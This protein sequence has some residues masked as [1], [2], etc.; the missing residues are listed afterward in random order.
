MFVMSTLLVKAQPEKYASNLEMKNLLREIRES[1]FN[2]SIHV[3]ELVENALATAQGN[4][5]KL[6]EVLV[7]LYHGNFY[8]QN[9]KFDRSAIKYAKAFQLSKE[10]KDTRIINL[11][12]IR[13]VFSKAEKD[14]FTA[15]KETKILLAEAEKNKFN[16][17][18]IEALNGLGYMFEKRQIKDEALEYY[19]RGLKLAEQENTPY[20]KAILLSNI[21]IIKL[22]NMQLAEAEKDFKEAL[23]YALETKD[24]RSELSIRNNL[25]SFY[26]TKGDFGSGLK[27]YKSCLQLAKKKGHAIGQGFSYGNICNTYHYL[28]KIDFAEIYID[29]AIYQFELEKDMDYL[30][31]SYLVKANL[32][33]EKKKYDKALKAVNKVL[34]THRIKRNMDNYIQAQ[35]V[36]AELYDQQGDYGKSIQY[37]KEHHRLK[38]SVSSK[39][40]YGKLAEMQALYGKEKLEYKLNTAHAENTILQKENELK[41]TRARLIIG[42]SIA[43]V[44]I[45]LGG[46][47]IR[48]VRIKKRNQALF[49]K[50]LIERVDEERSRIS[51]DL[52]DDIGQ[53][54]SLLRSKIDM[55]E[56]QKL[57]NLDSIKSEL[58]EVIEFTRNIS[59][60]LHPVFI[61]KIGLYRS[62][63]SLTNN[64]EKSTGII[65]SIDADES[66]NTLSL[67]RQ[68]QVFRILQECI[69]NTIKHAD[70]SALKIEFNS[71]GDFFEVVYR[72][73]GKKAF[74]QTQ[75]EGIGLMTIRERSNLLKA[76]VN[77]EF[78]P[79]GFVLTLK[80]KK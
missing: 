29:S 53:S 38:D 54:L 31:M 11:A 9:S 56:K 41:K 47:Y 39:T 35:L 23:R 6:D 25:G 78:T 67:D 34:E 79:K 69:N 7:Y 5:S 2:D 24:Y 71:Q 66:I 43:F 61:S 55:Y 63:V 44:I 20:Y 60:V 10:T 37:L 28:G 36:L 76:K 50:R 51:R 18:A 27:Q 26:L 59:H 1:A 16:E 45:V 32:A 17:N 14:I 4:K 75:N 46:F 58:S 13:Y 73:N 52:H 77:F 33:I 19:L 48:Y 21:G 22:N 57:E 72:D 74:Q 70:A 80:F 65:C 15:E 40:N 42:F 8:F 3:N 68:T 62:L 49:S 30:G 12:H 64:T